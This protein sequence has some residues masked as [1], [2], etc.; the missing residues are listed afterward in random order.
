MGCFDNAGLIT[1]S[2][3][4]VWK[5]RCAFKLSRWMRTHYLSEVDN[6]ER[7]LVRAACLACCAVACMHQ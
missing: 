2:V 5:L 6:P 3:T 7:E 4:G 1:D